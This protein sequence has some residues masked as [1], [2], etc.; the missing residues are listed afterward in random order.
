MAEKLLARIDP[1]QINYV[2]RIFEGYEYLGVL[3]T[4]N[5]EE[6]LIMIRTTPDCYKEAVAVLK[7]LPISVEF[8]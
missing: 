1:S 4:V 2:N 7:H 6:G 8:V 5:R 3:S